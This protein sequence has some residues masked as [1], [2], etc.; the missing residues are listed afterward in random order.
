M[1]KGKRICLERVDL[2]NIDVMKITFN[3]KEYAGANE[4]APEEREIYERAMASFGSG[5]ASDVKVET[6]ARIVVNGK[7]YASLD[8]MPADVRRLY[9][10]A[11]SVAG[12]KVFASATRLGWL[13]AGIV[14]G[15]LVAAALFQSKLF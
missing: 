10:L 13:A 4:M 2:R 8:A 6:K 3:G 1:T 12:R 14:I 7:E 9:E 11:T 15:S 5:A